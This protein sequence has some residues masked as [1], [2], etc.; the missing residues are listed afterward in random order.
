MCSSGAR[1]LTRIIANK[2]WKATIEVVR[3]V[4]KEKVTRSI[5]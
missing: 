2:P 5:S 3:L 1:E 4:I